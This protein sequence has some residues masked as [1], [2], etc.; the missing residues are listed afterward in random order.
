ML[1]YVYLVGTDEQEEPL[2]DRLRASA[3]A[4]ARGTCIRWTPMTDN[5]VSGSGA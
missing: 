3:D 2:E 1:R 5:N 4:L